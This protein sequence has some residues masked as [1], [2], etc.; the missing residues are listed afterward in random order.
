MAKGSHAPEITTHI[1]E[2]HDKPNIFG[3]NREPQG[4]PKVKEGCYEN[5]GKPSRQ[6][7]M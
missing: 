4:H 1:H 6:E 7:K 5:A 2:G 3:H